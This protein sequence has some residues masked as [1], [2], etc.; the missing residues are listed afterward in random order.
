MNI[1]ILSP[2]LP[3]PLD[4]GGKIRIYNIIKNMASAHTITLAT[5]VDDRST[6]DL[7]PLRQFC[8]E[9]ILVERPARLWPDRLAFFSGND[10]YNVIRYRCAELRRELLRL[11]RRKSFDL[12]QVEFPMMWQYAGLFRVLGTPVVLD[13][14]N[15][16]HYNVRQIGR[17][18]GTLFWRALYRLEERRLRRMEEQ[19]WRECARCFAVSDKERDEIAAVAGDPAKVVTVPNGVDPERFTFL[20]RTMTG[21]NIL[22]LGGMDY[23]PNLDAARW[24]LDEV[25]PL[26]L[27]QEPEAKLQ[28]VGRELWRL[29]EGASGSS[30]P[31]SRQTNPELH[32][33][34][35]DVLPWF[36]AADLLVVPL[37]MGA[38]TRLKILEA[39]AAGLPVVSTAK[40]CEGI[41]ASP[42]VH[43]LIADTGQDFAAAAASIMHDVE[44]GQRLAANARHLVQERYTWQQVIDLSGLE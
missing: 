24:L 16:E 38:G 8:D 17:S 39:M 23:I 1:L 35:P 6:A 34:V 31:G 28:M 29:K 43:L 11:Q 15:I 44:L 3:Y 41:S 9:I 18:A 37:R 25:F 5:L 19:A 10:P 21:K 40:G 4:Q 26:I 42:G 30:T 27:Q 33:N 36:Y 13:A 12:V 20:P 32:E 7:G 22:F 2:F 14:H